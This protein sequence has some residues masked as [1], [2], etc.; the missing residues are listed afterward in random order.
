MKT[1]EFLELLEKNKGLE[2][3]FEYLPGKLVGANYHITE[4]KNVTIDSVDCGAR[5]DSWKETVV[6]LWESPDEK[7]KKTFMSAFKAL[8][9]LKKVHRIKPM[10]LDTEI[11]FEYGNAQFHTAQLF[12]NGFTIENNALTVQLSTTKTDCK[13]KDVCGVEPVREVAAEACCAP[14]SGCC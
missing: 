9:I 13:A 5:T 2:T 10:Q 6:Q 3:R 12:V 11:K 14:G 8:G 4:V 1:S 7:D